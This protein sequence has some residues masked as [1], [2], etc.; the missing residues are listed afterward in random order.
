MAGAM[1]IVAN[2]GTEAPGD[3]WALDSLLDTGGAWASQLADRWTSEGYLLLVGETEIIPTFSKSWS[4]DGW[5]SGRVDYTDRNYASTDSASDNDTPELAVGRIP[6]NSAE[7][8]CRALKTAIQVARQPSLVANG[9]AYCISGDDP[10]DDE[11]FVAQRRS[12]AGLLADRGFAVTQHHQPS[13]INFSTTAQDQNVIFLSPHGNPWGTADLGTGD[14]WNYGFREQPSRC[15][16]RFLLDGPLPR[17]RRHLWGDLSLEQR[18]CL[19]RC[20]RTNLRVVL[21]RA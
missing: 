1:E 14:I 17:W 13:A 4:I 9:R 3:R 12:I 15:L 5:D 20:H 19:H 21:S 16:C 11:M 10:N 2:F 8:L 18:C 7:G 6:G